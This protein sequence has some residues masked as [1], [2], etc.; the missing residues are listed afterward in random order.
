MGKTTDAFERLCHRW[1]YRDGDIES[2]FGEIYRYH[3]EM[4]ENLFGAEASLPRVERLFGRLRELLEGETS[5]SYDYD[6]D[7]IIPF[8]ELLS[9]AIVSAY[10]QWTGLPD[11]WVD[12]R[13]CLKSDDRYRSANIDLQTSRQ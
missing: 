7:R 9:S 6:Y 5:M 3:N 2:V 11:C 13:K 12:I 4:I 10:L 1:F 8:G